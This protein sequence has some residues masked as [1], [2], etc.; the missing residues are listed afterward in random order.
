MPFE[1]T[2]WQRENEKVLT[3]DPCLSSAL[4]VF[5]TFRTNPNL[6]RGS[7]HWISEGFFMH[8]IQ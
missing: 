3:S 5:H 1:A 2:A 7:A 6:A 8:K 4:G